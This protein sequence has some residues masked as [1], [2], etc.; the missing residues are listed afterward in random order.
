MLLIK[1]LRTNVL[2][3]VLINT[4]FVLTLLSN[5]GCAD[6]ARS[7]EPKQ[8]AAAL[9]STAKQEEAQDGYKKTTLYDG[10]LELMIPADLQP[11]G[12]EGLAIKY[13]KARPDFAYAGDYGKVTL[14]FAIKDKPT[15]SNDI[16]A[17][18]ASIDKK[19]GRSEAYQSNIRTINGQQYVVSEFVSGSGAAKNN[20]VM[21][22][23]DFKGKLLLGTFNFPSESAEM[24]NAKKDEILSS[25]KKI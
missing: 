15:T 24:W 8:G 12:E 22:M 3:T 18:K 14:V 1:P 6:T 17:I 11:M 16:P 9:Q 21:F 5:S 23:T 4:F 10:R 20:N 7:D 2:A 25:V 13:P 19:M